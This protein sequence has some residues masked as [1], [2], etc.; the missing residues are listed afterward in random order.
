M[1]RHHR[2]LLPLQPKCRCQALPC[3]RSRRH[4]KHCY[5]S[6]ACID[7]TS[8]SW[9]GHGCPHL[10][11]LWPCCRIS[12]WRCRRGSRW[13]GSTIL[14]LK[15]S[16]GG[17]GSGSTSSH[18]SAASAP[19]AKAS[20]SVPGAVKWHSR[21]CTGQRVGMVPKVI[22]L[23]GTCFDAAPLWA[24]MCVADSDTGW[25]GSQPVAGVGTISAARHRMIR[26]RSS[27]STTS[28]A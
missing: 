24:V 1:T 16:Q 10:N 4:D 28:R 3:F 2:Q 7:A 17:R 5:P 6:G 21:S 18:P 27:T 26:V 15:G 20:A 13:M 12:C 19:S 8:V 11:T 25:L 23:P 22:V 9:H 14:I